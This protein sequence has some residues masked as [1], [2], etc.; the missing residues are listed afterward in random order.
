MI[1][2]TFLQI[3][4]FH[5]SFAK[6]STIYRSREGTSIAKP[7]NPSGRRKQC[8]VCVECSLLDQAPSSSP[9]SGLAAAMATSLPPLLAAAT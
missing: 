1:S 6:P 2:G 8:R 7:Y 3:P 9:T 4:S 5:T